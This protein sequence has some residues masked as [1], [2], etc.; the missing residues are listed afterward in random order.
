MRFWIITLFTFAFFSTTFGQTDRGKKP[1]VVGQNQLATDEDQSLTLQLSDFQVED[2][3]W[4]YPW[5]YSLVV[6]EGNNYV[7]NGNTITPVLNFSGPLSVNIAIR[8]GDKESDVYN[9]QVTVHP[10]NDPPVIKGQ[11]AIS[12]TANHSYTIQISDLII[13]DPDNSTFTMLVSFG[14]NYSVSGETITPAPGF[15]GNLSVGLLV[16]DGASYS[17][18]YNLLIEVI[19]EKGIPVITAQ[20]P[21]SID[22]DN[23]FAL[24]F[25]DLS[26]S[27]PDSTYPNGFTINIL[28][29]SNFSSSNNTITPSPDFNGLLSVPV[30]VNDGKN[31]SEPFSLSIKVNP[32]NDPPKIINIETTPLL[33][34]VGKGQN[35][36]TK[37]FN[38]IEVEND[39]ILSAELIFDGG[40]YSAGEDLLIFTNTQQIQGTFD[41]LKGKLVLTGKAPVANYNEAIK[42]I[43][44]NY[45]FIDEPAFG[46]KSISI[47]LSEKDLSSEPAER[48]I[49]LTDL[50]VQLD[51]PTGFTPN[52]DFINDTWSIRAVKTSEELTNILVRVYNKSGKLLYE[53]KGF[54]KEWDGR[55]N[56]E[57]LPSDTY[58]FTI[59]LNLP[60]SREPYKG[61]VT[62]L[63]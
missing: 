18:Y 13:E 30:T 20:V 45:S 2:K 24:N 28:N 9:A 49:K 25:S 29:G 60:F 50:I 41:A 21:I 23:S 1:K 62:I 31:T 57:I 44:Y 56:G 5:G 38:A 47:I 61:I 3:S 22:E 17:N 63:R 15:T 11:N 39:S 16:N 34:E 55:Y 59:D 19:P 27:D 8:N 51:I 54:D 40:N 10:I 37:E 12:I 26:V 43:Y 14:A 53:S 48:Q 42:S 33:F 35:F 58:F 52:G 36:L 7:V 46:T 6:Y 4:L 32:V